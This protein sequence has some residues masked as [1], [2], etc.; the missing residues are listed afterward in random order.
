MLAKVL[1]GSVKGPGT[2]FVATLS[3]LRGNFTS[4]FVCYFFLAQRSSDYCSFSNFFQNCL[5]SII[6]RNFVSVLALCIS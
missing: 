6:S 4:G 2:Y 3:S 1:L 5:V